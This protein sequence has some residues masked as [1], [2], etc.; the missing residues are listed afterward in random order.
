M[1]SNPAIIFNNVDFPHPEGPNKTKKLPSSISKLIFL[2]TSV[3]P[4]FFDKSS[5]FNVFIVILSLLLK[6]IL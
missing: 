2:N 4:K 1:V 3:D 6:L 5:I